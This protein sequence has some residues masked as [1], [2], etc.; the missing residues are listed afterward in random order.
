M[1]EHRVGKLP[2]ELPQ[3][4]SDFGT[5]CW[6]LVLAAGEKTGGESSGA[7]ERLCQLYW[8]PVYAYIRRR[9]HQPSDAED[10]TQGF[11]AQIL[12]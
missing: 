5:T 7:L 2:P 4:P 8:Y 6:T 11:S 3:N 12:G 10:L 1:M 9:G